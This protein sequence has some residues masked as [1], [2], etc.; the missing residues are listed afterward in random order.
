MS[1]GSQTP[2]DARDAMLPEDWAALSPLVDAV[3]DLPD[4]ER[5]ARIVE[6][7]GGDADRGTALRAMVADCEREMPKLDVPA[8]EQFAQLIA[9]EPEQQLPDLLGD[10]YRI[11]REIGRGGMARVFLAV[12]AKH[13]RKVAVKVIRPELAASLG[14]ERF[15]REIGIAARLRHPNIVPLY[16]SGDADGVLYFVMPYEDGQS[17]RQRIDDKTPL[18]T[19]EYVSVLRDV[20][21]ALAYAHEQGVVHRDVKPDNVMLSRAAAV[22]T[23]FGIAKAVS[24]AQGAS[25]STTTLTHTGSGIGTP[26]Y[27]APEQAVGD[28]ATD[29]RAD[30]YSFGCLAYELISGQPPFHD[31][32]I[33]QLIAA[34]VAT[35][36]LDIAERR[37]DVPKSVSRLVMQCLEK[38]PADRPQSADAVLL[39]LDSASALA[40]SAPVPHV[41]QRERAEVV[42]ASVPVLKS[43]ARRVLL[44]GAA[45][46]VGVV[47]FVAVR[48]RA[49]APLPDV[50]VAVL[51]LQS[52]GDEPVQRALAAGLSDEVAIELFRVP[53]L[54]VMSRRGV[55][56]YREQRNMDTDKLGRALGARFLVMG[57]VREVNG[58]LRVLAS[59]VRATDG[60]VLW[61]DRFD[62][63][64]NELGVVRTEMARAIGDTLRRLVPASARIGPSARA[65]TP[66]VVNPEAYRLYVLAQRALDRRGQ[67]IRSSI[68]NFQ[69][70]TVIDTNYAE[71]WAGLSLARALTP[72]FTPITSQAIEP[73]VRAA[74]MRALSL[75]SSLATAHVA[76][77]LAHQ[78]AY[79]WD[80]AAT[81]FQTAVRL[82]TAGDVEPVIQY[83]RHLLFRGRVQDGM[84]QLM[85][86]RQTEPASAVV[87][88][89]LSYAFYLD[90][91][92]DSALSE[93]RH[94]DQSD[95]T[96]GFALTQGMM[97]RLH[98]GL[99]AEARHYLD[100]ISPYVPEALYGLS[101]LGDSAEAMTRLRH[102]EAQLP[103]PGSVFFGR[104]SAMLGLRDTAAALLALERSTDARELWPAHRS[105]LEPFYAPLW[106]SARFRALLQR[107]GL[108]DIKLPSHPPR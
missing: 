5:E 53:G 33:H 55:D 37:A 66:R 35:T 6:L 17:L 52:D 77:G 71:A 51:P 72:F 74:A 65:P 32:P 68:D 75:D 98:L 94:A 57:N 73:A 47:A 96:N 100:R 108:G 62:R 91:Q 87:S 84:Q 31:L 107:V 54:H 69:Q 58:R 40:P 105:V 16:D 13:N 86:A 95:S 43:I 29:H 11:E 10:R 89:W 101:A 24:V 19:S 80:S 60:A 39:V 2:K 15:L 28:P 36:P 61:S 59:L 21:R 104:A 76:L 56:N 9:D 1:F 70:A 48:S 8:G 63:A 14:R 41:P 85:L 30:I 7:T 106:P 12:D 78:H 49:A 92:L 97:L 23:D 22:V 34:H 25:G 44:V 103:R 88:S 46:A 27:M 18:A 64:Q 3:L 81:E 45:L 20:A 4:A 90:G 42:P 79:R 99:T 67:S 93:S 50:T 38:E 83:G 82:R 102:M 26:T